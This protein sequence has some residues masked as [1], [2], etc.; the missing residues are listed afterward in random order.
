MSDLN[1]RFADALGRIES[2][3]PVA[4]IW[5]IVKEFSALLGYTHLA[6]ADAARLAG[7]ATNAIFYTDAPRVPAEIDRTYSY[8][9]APFVARVLRSPDTFLLSELR[10]D[11]KTAGPWTTLLAD[12]VK[13]GEGLIVP[14]YEGGEPLAGF[15]F[16]GEKPNTS[17]QVRAMLQVLSHAAF[18]RYRRLQSPSSQSAPHGLTVREIQCLR[19]IAAGQTD[20]QAGAKLS[21]SPRTVRFHVNNA[22]TKL[23]AKTRMQAIAKAMSEKIITI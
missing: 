4:L 11:T 9:S 8:A 17:A 16:G 20:S 5:T 19:A 10:D 13:R 7:G 21:I 22:K 1:T 12:V 14:V 3:S 18:A 23:K 15:I 6:G 2:A